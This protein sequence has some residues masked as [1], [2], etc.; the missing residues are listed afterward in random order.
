[1]PL[2]SVIEGILLRD[3]RI[4]PNNQS[5]I[6]TRSEKINKNEQKLPK[7][8]NL[9]ERIAVFGP[10]KGVGGLKIVLFCRIPGAI[11]PPQ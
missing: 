8:V 6:T 7:K 11:G 4:D 2:T 3:Q 9:W 5:T 10:I 1:M